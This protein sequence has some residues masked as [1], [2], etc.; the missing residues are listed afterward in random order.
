VEY[1][2]FQQNFQLLLCIEHPIILTLGVR[3]PVCPVQPLQ[4]GSFQSGDIVGPE[5]VFEQFL[6]G[7]FHQT[8]HAQALP[9]QVQHD[10]HPLV[11]VEFLY[12]TVFV[13]AQLKGEHRVWLVN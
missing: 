13:G 12:E 9:K 2:L 11:Q 3:A 8:E 7:V 1:C 5:E 4:L 10:S 6:L